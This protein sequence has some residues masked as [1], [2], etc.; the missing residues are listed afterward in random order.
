MI[1]F[2]IQINELSPSFTIGFAVKDMKSF[3]ILMKQLY[4]LGYFIDNNINKSAKAYKNKL[5]M[6]KNFKTAFVKY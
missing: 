5:F 1:I 3:K 2:Y 6:V 4:S